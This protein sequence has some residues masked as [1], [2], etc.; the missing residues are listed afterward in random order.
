MYRL[1][2]RD[3]YLAYE[4]QLLRASS[5]NGEVFD[6]HAVCLHSPYLPH[7]MHTHMHTHTYIHKTLFRLA[8]TPFSYER[9]E[10]QGEGGQ[11]RRISAHFLVVVLRGQNEESAAFD[12]VTSSQIYSQY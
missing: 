11:L 12:A 5:P 3:W 6:E 10:Q 9:K 8:P 7:R 1:T 2:C 4:S